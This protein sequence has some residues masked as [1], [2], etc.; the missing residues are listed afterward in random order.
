MIFNT[1]LVEGKF[2][3][4]YKRFFVD[5]EVIDQFGQ[6]NIYTA[7]TANT[8]S[9][10][11][12]IDENYKTFSSF[13]DDPNRKLKYSLEMLHNGSTFIGI[14]TSITNKLVQE[15]IIDGTISEL[16]NPT[17]IK[18]EFKI[19]KSRI[20]FFLEFGNLKCFVEVKNV[21]LKDGLAAKFPDAV[22]ERGQKHLEELISIKNNGDRAVLLFVI[23]REDVDYFNLENSIDP[24]YSILLDKA[25]SAGVEVLAYQCKLSQSEIKIF[26]KLEIKKGP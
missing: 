16:K 17:F 7:H 9:M 14:N 23:Q 19:G 21:T 25:M 22:T 13:H 15:A 20:D 4:R 3:K 5:F 6:T 1:T 24:K 11:S 26:K 18:P 10:K 8:G 2:L 12:C